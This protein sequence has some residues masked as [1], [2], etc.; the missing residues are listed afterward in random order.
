L[1]NE[2]LHDVYCQPD[3]VWVIRSRGTDKQGVWHLMDRKKMHRWVWWRN[4]KKEG[5]LT[6]L[7]SIL[8]EQDFRARIGFIW[9]KIKTRSSLL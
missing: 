8:K 5:H 3:R 7:K 6:D 2:E 4:L 1:H 9:L